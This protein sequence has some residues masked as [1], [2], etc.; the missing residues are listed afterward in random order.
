MNVHMKIFSAQASDK[1]NKATS[2]KHP[3]IMMLQI[4]DVGANFFFSISLSML[5][6]ASIYKKNRL[7]LKNQI[8]GFIIIRKK[9]KSK[10]QMRHDFTSLIFI[11]KLIIVLKVSWFASKLWSQIMEYTRWTWREN[12]A[13][14]IIK[15]NKVN[16]SCQKQ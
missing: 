7:K 16:I 8:L 1:I 15:M 12:K 11:H 6:A 9:K 4:L 14:T 3:A 5:W 10:W 13:L 2:R